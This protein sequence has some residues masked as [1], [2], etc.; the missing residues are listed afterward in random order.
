VL[1]SGLF[2]ATRDDPAEQVGSG[3]HQHRKVPLPL[4]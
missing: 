2:D 3:G 4:V 1:T